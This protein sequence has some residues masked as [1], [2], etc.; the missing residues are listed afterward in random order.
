MGR[1]AK[2]IEVVD[3]TDKDINHYRHVKHQNVNVCI[4][5]KF[6]S[7]SETY[8][9]QILKLYFFKSLNIRAN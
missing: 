3:T 7:N 2:K 4:T 5:T 9:Q 1:T 6:K 8:V